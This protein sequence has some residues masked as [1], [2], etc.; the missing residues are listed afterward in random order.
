VFRMR[1]LWES[2][3]SQEIREGES[4]EGIPAGEMLVQ[5]R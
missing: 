5:V 4:K 1:F 2:N 3:T